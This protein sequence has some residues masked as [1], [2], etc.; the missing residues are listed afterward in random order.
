[1]ALRRGARGPARELGLQN[2]ILHSLH[3]GPCAPCARARA[4]A[5]SPGL[6]ISVAA[7][8]GHPKCA[9]V[10]WAFCAMRR[11]RPGPTSSCSACSPPAH[12]VIVGPLPRTH[13][14]RGPCAHLAR[15]RLP[16]RAGSPPKF[17]D[18]IKREYVARSSLPRAV[19]PARATATSV[20]ACWAFTTTRMMPS[21]SWTQSARR[22]RWQ[23]FRREFCL[24][25]LP[26]KL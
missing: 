22:D 10:D 17:S 3:R 14:V 13:L 21:T 20:R 4:C 18:F 9:A 15:G 8:W 24:Q 25:M 6:S 11:P 7:V 23:R 19:A 5:A 2:H 12:L 1:M 26:H 16:A